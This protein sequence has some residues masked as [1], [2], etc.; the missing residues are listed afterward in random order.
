MMSHNEL[1]ALKTEEDLV[2]EVKRRI[3]YAKE[4]D[5]HYYRLAQ[6]LLVLAVIASTLVALSSAL[7]WH[8][9]ITISLALI[10]AFLYAIESRLKFEA[11]SFFY[12][13]YTLGLEALLLDLEYLRKPMDGL[14]SQLQQLERRVEFPRLGRETRDTD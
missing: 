2:R 3:K 12:Y 10:P 7:E 14:I 6:I 9:N 4:R 8:K 11:K 13:D 5:W 1:T